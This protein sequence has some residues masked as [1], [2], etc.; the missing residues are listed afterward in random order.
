[1]LMQGAGMQS[2]LVNVI[3]YMSGRS[4]RPAL[5]LAAGLVGE[6][7]VQSQVECSTCALAVRK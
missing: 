1:M 3:A 4:A 6:L 7:A 2:S 5:W